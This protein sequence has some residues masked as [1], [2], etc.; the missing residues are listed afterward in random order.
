[1]MTAKNSKILRYLNL[2]NIDNTRQRNLLARY[3]R[4]RYK[5]G[6][7][8]SQGMTAAIIMIAFIIT[9]AGIA[10]V[11]LT[12]GTSMQQQLA[13]TGERGNEA[14]SSAMQFQ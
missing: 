5:R 9:A 2:Q 13:T 3:R 14:A 10:F 8:A 12:M 7:R 11:I 4:K 1:M 6:K